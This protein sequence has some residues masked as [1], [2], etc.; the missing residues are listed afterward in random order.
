MAAMGDGFFSISDTTDTCGW[1]SDDISKPDPL[2]YAYIEKVVFRDVR[3]GVPSILVSAAHGQRQ[4]TREDV[5]VCSQQNRT[6][7]PKSPSF[8]PAATRYQV[9]FVF[10]GDAYLSIFTAAK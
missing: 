3:G 6:K 5:D 9:D 10:E 4:M 1:M 7:E 8:L 2:I